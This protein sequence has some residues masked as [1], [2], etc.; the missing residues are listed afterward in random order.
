VLGDWLVAPGDTAQPGQA[1]ATLVA[2][3][4]P[5]TVRAEVPL[6]AARRLRVGE[7]AEVSV[8]GKARTYPGKIERI[9]FRLAGARPGEPPD[10]ETLGRTGVTVIVTSE[11]PFDFANLGYP[12]SVS[13]H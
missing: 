7:A 9:D 3:D 2:A 10:L 13:F 6:A 5:L 1:V 8:P 11:R 4:Q 12:V